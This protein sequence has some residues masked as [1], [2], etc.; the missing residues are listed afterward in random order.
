MPIVFQLTPAT[1]APAEMHLFLPKQRV[2]NLAENATKTMHNLLPFRGTEV[3]D[4]S[5]WSQY[6]GA[7]LERFGPDTDVLIAQHHWPTWGNARVARALLRGA[8]MLHAAAAFS[9]RDIAWRCRL[10]R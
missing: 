2:L 4:A 8:K 7:A 6:L 9:T 1:E 5:A 10:T 3:R